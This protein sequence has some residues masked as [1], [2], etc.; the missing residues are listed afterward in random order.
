[1]EDKSTMKKMLFAVILLGVASVAQAAFISCAPAQDT[2]VTEGQPSS[3]TFTCNPGAGT[4]AG[5]IDNN[6]AGDN[7][8]VTSIRLRVSGTFQENNAVLSQVYSVLY[9]TTNSGG[10]TNTTCLATATGDAS[11]F[12]LGGCI[13][14]GAGSAVASLDVVPQFTITVAGGAGS[15]PLPFNGSAS[16]SYEVTA[17]EIPS[18]VPEPA[19][20][21]VMG[22]GLLALG[23][24]ARRRRK[25]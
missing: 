1:L 7:Y 14:T 2:V 6:L 18:G 17:S 19:T 9:S 12:A 4:D 10:L 5:S 3:A 23:A 13:G 11:H 21:V 15:N 20:F 24:F 22:S 8:L 16:V 25:S